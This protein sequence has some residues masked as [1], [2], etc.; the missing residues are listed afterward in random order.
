ADAEQPRLQPQEPAAGRGARRVG[1]RP[2]D[3]GRRDRLPAPA[4]A[5]GR[6]PARGEPEAE[7][8]PLHPVGGR[9]LD[10][11]LLP[12]PRRGGRG[13]VPGSDSARGGRSRVAVGAERAVGAAAPQTVTR[14][15]SSIEVRPARTLAMPSSQ[16][17]R[18]PPAIA[19]RS[20]SSLLALRTASSAIASVMISSWKIPSRPRY[21]VWL[22]RGQPRLR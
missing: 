22:H 2:V 14:A 6:D 18:M 16:R 12:T 15:S 20:I 4:P 21:P 19:S 13:R 9:H 7:V 5:G 11:E 3:A 10:R 8:H 1:G 17:V